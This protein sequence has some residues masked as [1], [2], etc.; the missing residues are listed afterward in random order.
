[1]Q[2]EATFWK[3]R[4]LPQ[5]KSPCVRT[6]FIP[7]EVWPHVDASLA[8]GRANEARPCRSGVQHHSSR[9]PT[10][11]GMRRRPI[12]ETTVFT[13]EFEFLPSGLIPLT[14]PPPLGS[15]FEIT[16]YDLA[17]TV[18]AGQRGPV[19]KRKRAVVLAN[20]SPPVFSNGPKGVHRVQTSGFRGVYLWS[21]GPTK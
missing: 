2:R 8:A 12:T 14:C 4:I 17:R 15:N 18:G 10:T 20:C 19:S 7:M 11:P 6:R 3:L 9:Q 16:P 21:Y 13:A 5:L 1:M